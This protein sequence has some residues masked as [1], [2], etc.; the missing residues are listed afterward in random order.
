MHRYELRPAFFVLASSLLLAEV[1][2]AQQPGSP[3]VVVR[4]ETNRAI[5][6]TPVPADA[7]GPDTQTTLIPASAF[8]PGSSTYSY[9][10]FFGETITPAAD[11]NQ[12]W[13]AALALPSGA[14]VTEVGL[15]V[16]DTDAAED[17]TGF[18]MSACF[19]VT[20]TGPHGS[21]YFWTASSS[22]SAGDDV[23]T[24]TGSPILVRGGGL[25]AIGGGDA[26]DSYFYTYVSAYLET[27]AHSLSG[28]VVKWS[29]SVSPAPVV[30]TFGDVPTSHPFFQFI[31]ALSESGITA[32]CGGG[33]YCPDNPLT[34]GQM[35]VFLAKA[36]GL[37]WPL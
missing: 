34:R 14:V 5:V 37:H 10:N 27:T 20:D 31:E 11:G 29:R 35:A 4:M 3:D 7:F 8:V 36:L 32:G 6:S 24:M 15:M 25:C 22:G 2:R 9:S 19:P 18:F 28:A 17:I 13:H 33:N 23:V 26:F 16:T 1:A 21:G 12:R 30:A